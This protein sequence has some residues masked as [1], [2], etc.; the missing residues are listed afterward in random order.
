M[1]ET[2]R[3]ILAIVSVSVIAA[4]CIGKSI[5]SIN[6]LEQQVQ[7]ADV[8]VKD[9]TDF[10]TYTTGAFFEGKPTPQKIMVTYWS[11]PIGMLGP[12]FNAY[13]YT[14]ESPEFSHYAQLIQP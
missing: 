5:Q 4:A 2:T 13:V 9:T 11:P 10:T 3:T 14:Q 8:V 1:K 7:S 6:N 12:D